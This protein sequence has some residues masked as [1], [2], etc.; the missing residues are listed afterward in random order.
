M[1]NLIDRLNRAIDVE[2]DA[3]NQE[4]DNLLLLP[5]EDRVRKGDSLINLEIEIINPFLKIIGCGKKEEGKSFIQIDKNLICFTEVKIFCSENLSKYREGSPVVLHNSNYSFNLVVK[6]DNDNEMILETNWMEKTI[7]KSLIKSSG[8]QLDNAKS[9]IRHIVKKSTN[10]LLCNKEKYNLINGIFQGNILP[11]ISYDKLQFGHELATK[12]K[13][14]LTQKNAFAHAYSSNNYFLIQGP[15]GSGKTW[16]LAH[17]A[18]QFAIEGKKVLITAPTHT[19]I[20]NALQKCSTLTQYEHIVKVGESNQKEGLNYDGS[21]ARNSPDFRNTA[22]NNN[23]TGVIVGA[24]CYSPHTR[25]LEFMDWD[26]IIF[27]EAGQLSIPLA[28]AAMVKGSKFIF[29][30]DHKQLPPIIA[31]DHTDEVFQKSIFEHLHQ[32]DAGIM[33]DITYRMNKWINEFPSKQFYDGKLTPDKKNEAW[34]INTPNKFE[35]HEEILS[36]DKPEVLYCHYHESNE[37]RSQYEAEIIAEFIEEYLEQEI[38][39]ED[40][41]ILTPFRAQVR[42]IKK[43]L[44]KLNNYNDFKEKLFLDTVERIQGQERDIV[45]FSLATSDPIKAMQ[46][47]TFFFNPNRFN[48]AI[49]RARKKRIVIGHKNLFH[50]SSDDKELNKMISIFR[51]FYNYSYKV[52]EQVETEDLF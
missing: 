10:I 19:A 21:T 27:D 47:A 46:R 9:D 29:I 44:A 51:D 31:E 45:I 8:W 34:L 37:P 4:V 36:A 6:E 1:E 26:V 18:Y 3:K 7:D 12:T 15:P 16:L 22:Y 5:I 30:G 41:A 2:Y 35:K 48:V 40:I 33:L 38:D 14:N 13:L 52:F 50:L 28:I 49:T 32:F 42:Q 25:K 39:P 43:A 24:T 11:D 20:N 17:L 23:S